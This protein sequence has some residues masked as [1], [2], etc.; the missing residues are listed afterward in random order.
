MATPEA[1]TASIGP[2]DVLETKIPAVENL[3]PVSAARGVPKAEILNW[4]PRQGARLG[5]SQ[6][7]C[8]PGLAVTSSQEVPLGQRPSPPNS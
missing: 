5:P 7:A 2:K 8:F 1:A 3:G 4:G 6:G